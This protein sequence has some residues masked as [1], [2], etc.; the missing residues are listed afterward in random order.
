MRKSDLCC[1]ISDCSIAPP[2]P[3]WDAQWIR[4]VT[5]IH[6]VLHLFFCILFSPPSGVTPAG[7]LH[8]LLHPFLLFI[9]FI[10]NFFVYIVSC[11]GLLLIAIYTCIGCFYAV[12][13]VAHWLYYYNVLAVILLYKGC[14]YVVLAVT[15]WLYYYNV[16]AIILYIMHY[17]TQRTIVLFIENCKEIYEFMGCFKIILG[18]HPG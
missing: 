9:L 4:Y 1:D 10:I 16:L 14:F 13:A 2:T 11:I 7:A 8:S 17:P 18:D 12:L 6:I 5:G 15:L 3:P